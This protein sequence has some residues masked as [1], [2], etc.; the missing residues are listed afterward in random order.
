MDAQNYNFDPEFSQK[1]WFL[2][3]FLCIWTKIFDN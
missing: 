2:A 3:E 1:W